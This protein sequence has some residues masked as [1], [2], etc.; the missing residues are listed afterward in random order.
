MGSL[1][2]SG[3]LVGDPVSIKIY[4]RYEVRTDDASP[5]ASPA[6]S[7]LII[8]KPQKAGCMAQTLYNFNHENE[9]ELT[10]FDDNS[11][12]YYSTSYFVHIL[13]MAVVSYR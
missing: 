10:F 5:F 12:W 4:T 7:K 13:I 2:R 9:D 8:S 6:S 11:M 1:N 3:N